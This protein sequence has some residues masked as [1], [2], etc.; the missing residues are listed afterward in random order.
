[1]GWHR[2]LARLS[3][4]K[5]CMGKWKTKSFHGWQRLK[6]SATS[7]SSMRSRT[8]CDRKHTRGPQSTACPGGPKQTV[9]PESVNSAAKMFRETSSMFFL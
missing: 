6:Y 4:E 8:R 2:K 7:H 9:S 3:Q 1:M 5:S